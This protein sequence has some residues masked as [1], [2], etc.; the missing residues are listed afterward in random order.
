MKNL[1]ATLFLIPFSFNALS[2]DSLPTDL[3]AWKHD[4]EKGCELNGKT[5]LA[6]EQVSMNGSKIEKYITDNPGAHVYDSYGVIMQCQY[7]VD[8][9]SSDHPDINERKYVWVSFSW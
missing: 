7:L 6:G 2:Y 9:M 5:Y 8:K 3:N 1:L 4:K